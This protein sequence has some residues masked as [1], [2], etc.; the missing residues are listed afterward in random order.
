MWLLHGGQE[1]SNGLSEWILIWFIISR[2]FLQFLWTVLF[3]KLG[4]EKFGGK[5][6]GAKYITNGWLNNIVYTKMAL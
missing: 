6:K 2:D 5:G 4:R 1:K 3:R